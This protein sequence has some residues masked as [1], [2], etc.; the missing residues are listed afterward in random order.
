MCNMEQS[1]CLVCIF[2]IAYMAIT[3]REDREQTL[4]M[5][6]EKSTNAQL[7]KSV[8]YLHDNFQS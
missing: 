8:K 1:A 7:A 5:T 4:H 2:G 6:S 3:D